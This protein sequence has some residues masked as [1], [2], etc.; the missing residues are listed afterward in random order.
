MKEIKA[1]LQPHVLTR[2]M[3]ALHSLP[4]FPGATV[5]DCQG[6]GRGRGKG[7]SYVPNEETIFF[8]KKSKLEIFCADALC[9][10]FVDVIQRAAH[11]GHPGDGVIMVADLH[12]VVRIR[13]GEEQDE[14]V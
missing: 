7:G 6:Q 11:T 12:R 5:S 13:T 9:D 10:E 4:H 8:S 1:V 3:E 2:V 14:A